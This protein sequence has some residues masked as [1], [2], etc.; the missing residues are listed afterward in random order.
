MLHDAYLFDSSFHCRAGPLHLALR[1][2]S[3]F[4][5]DGA[6]F[7]A[8]FENV[9]AAAAKIWRRGETLLSSSPALVRTGR[10]LPTPALIGAQLAQ[11]FHH[12]LVIFLTLFLFAPQRIRQASLNKNA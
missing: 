8:R 7:H 4:L 11:R 12:A 2:F 6:D 10:P 1:V 9:G 3:F 5:L